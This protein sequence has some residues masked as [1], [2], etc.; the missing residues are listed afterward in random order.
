MHCQ[1]AVD[2]DGYPKCSG[3]DLIDAGVEE[4]QHLVE[5][6]HGDLVEKPG[7]PSPVVDRLD[8]LD[9]TKPVTELSSGNAT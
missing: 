4:A 8:L 5:H 2:A 9:Q 3:S 7:S 1:R 6:V